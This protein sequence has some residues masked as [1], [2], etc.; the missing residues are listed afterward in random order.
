[1]FYDAEGHE[2]HPGAEV[3]SGHGGDQGVVVHDHLGQ[4]THYV[5]EVLL[6]T[7]LEVGSYVDQF[8]QQVHRLVHTALF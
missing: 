5:A 3:V 4:V 8:A 2:E 7:P 1:M 6:V